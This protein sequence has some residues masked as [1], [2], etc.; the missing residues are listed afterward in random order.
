MKKI[1]LTCFILLLLGTIGYSQQY[2]VPTCLGT[3]ASSIYGPMNSVVT[4]G[5]TS[6]TAA[7]YPASQLA[8]ISGQTLTSVY[9]SRIGTVGPMSGTP[10]FKVYLKETSDSDFGGNALIWATAITG[11]TL[12]YDSNPTTNVGST[13][14]WKAFPL[15]T[16]YTYS[17][18]QNL[19]VLM[20][21]SN[22]VAMSNAVQWEYEFQ[23]PCISTANNNTGKYVNST[24][25]VLG[26]NLSSSNYRRAFIGFD[27][28]VSCNAPTTVA[29]SNI[30][31]TSATV[32][33]TPSS[34]LPSLGHD[35]FLSTVNTPPGIS[36]IP[37]GNLPTG[38]VVNLIDLVPNT[39]YYI[40]VR[41]NC[42]ETDGFS[43]LASGSFRTACGEVTE[44]TEV[45]EGL[46]TGTTSPMPPCWAKAGAGAVYPTTG[47]VAPMSPANRLYMT[48]TGVT[49]TESYAI[50]PAVSNLQANTHRLRFKAYSIS[51]TDRTME[52][53]YVTNPEDI[54][55]YVY[56]QD[57]N[58]PG[59]AAGSAEE[60]IIYPG[61]LP[62]GVK[63]LVFKNPGHP[64][65]VNTLY[66]DD[67]IWQQS[68]SCLEVSNVTTTLVT[69]NSAQINWTNG[70][71]E[72]AW[73]IEYGTPGFTLG[74][75]VMA[76]N[77]LTNPHVLTGLSSNTNYQYY[78][79]A[80][81]SVSDQSAWMGPYNFKTLCETVTD[82]IVNFEGLPNRYRKFTRLL[83]KIRNFCECLYYN[84]KCSS[85]VACK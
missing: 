28:L 14:G 36:D 74:T 59:T 27:F 10:N 56:L 62:V 23:S 66:I 13:I 18:S 26:D 5:A 52:V 58:L 76:S 55:T 34:I 54:S 42:G 71:T 69:E 20:E 61:A 43:T 6:R 32:S 40:W 65:A 9:F 25:G 53:G 3:V 64:G 81:C 70:A 16:N 83:V 45:F 47:S 82:Y 38:S 78:I 17:G 84:W 51:G 37:T 67:V 29:A 33:F 85:H 80:V 77:V 75:G 15:S 73:D 24:T 41:G 48:A 7:L 68:P 22:P 50:L 30:T 35:Y 72:T 11:A 60:F 19:V 46:P 44:F 4:A 49:P 31:T 63:H 8:G 39:Q 79:R 57:V 21:Y 12:V 2:Q 1:T